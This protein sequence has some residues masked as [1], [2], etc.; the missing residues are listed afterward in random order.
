MEIWPPFCPFI[1][2]KKIHVSRKSTV[3]LVSKQ[4]TTVSANMSQK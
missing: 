4:E 3:I 1:R 2:L